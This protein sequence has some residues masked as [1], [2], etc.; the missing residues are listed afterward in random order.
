MLEKWGGSQP[1]PNVDA[2]SFRAGIKL[3]YIAFFRAPTGVWT[4]KSFKEN[5]ESNP[6]P[7]IMA[8][9]LRKAGLLPEGNE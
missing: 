3:G 2:Y 8:E 1:P 7:N 9:A 5:D 6:H 4:I